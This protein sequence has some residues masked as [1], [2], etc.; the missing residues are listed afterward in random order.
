M[1]SFMKKSLF[2]NTAL[3]MVFTMGFL[4][5]VPRIEASFVTSHESFSSDFRDKDLGII[6]KTLENKLIGERLKALG[7]S[8][9]EILTRLDYLS[10]EEVHQIATQMDA[11]APGGGFLEAV[12]AILIIV[13][14]VFLILHLADRRIVIR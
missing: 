3:L 4:C 11:I 8:E 1:Q 5:F 6:Q 2:R 10:D 9:Q 12:I 13:A 7:Y 14:L